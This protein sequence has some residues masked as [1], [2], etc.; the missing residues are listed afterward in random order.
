MTQSHWV[1]FNFK[2]KVMQ[3]LKG[4]FKREKGVISGIASTETPDRDGE[5]I[6][7]DGWDLKN[8]LNNPVIMASHKYSEFPIGRATGLAIVDSKLKFR[9]VLSK[10]TQTARDASAL[11]KEGILNSFSVGFI[12]R[13]RDEKDSKIISKAELL[14]ISLVSVPANPEAIITA[15]KFKNNELAKDLIKTS[16]ELRKKKD[17]KA[18]SGRNKVDV[19]VKL[20]KKIT[21]HLQELCSDVNR[22]D[23]VKK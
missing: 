12:P 23:G 21:G 3:K 9:M 16:S 11:I 19:D 20:L 18:G 5:S 6:K 13:T 4:Y 8:F 14:E 15:K 22:K 1:F 10:A 17:G 7:Q 2:N